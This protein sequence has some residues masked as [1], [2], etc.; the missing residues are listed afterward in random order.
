MNTAF[1]PVM[2][3][4]FAHINA[5]V[6]VPF[7]ADAVDG[8][9]VLENAVGALDKLFPGLPVFGPGIASGAVI[10]AVDI[11]A[12]T[13]TL[14]DPVNGSL[15]SADFTTGFL[16]S[17]TRVQHWQS[18]DAQPAFFL[19]RTGV[20]DQYSDDNCLAVTT[21]QC[22]AWIYCNSG[23]NPDANPDDMLSALEQMVRD[24]FAPDGEY[25]DPRFTLG[26]LVYWCRIQGHTDVSSG[27]QGPQAITRIPIMI[28]LP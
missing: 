17:D 25:G 27:D 16:T 10:S 13:V 12:Q 22:E 18:V 5:A 2:Q 24:S 15:P 9:A 11:G 1:R 19:R 23:S 7:V 26:G 3:A 20:I 21:L 14:T 28:T 6:Q 4:L 8:S